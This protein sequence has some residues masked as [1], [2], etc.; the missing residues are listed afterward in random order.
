MGPLAFYGMLL[1]LPRDPVVSRPAAFFQQ[2]DD[3]L[4]FRCSFG[5]HGVL[6]D[7]LK[8]STHPSPML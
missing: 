5:E 1:M 6:R 4:L 8:E 2:G 3:A 7:L